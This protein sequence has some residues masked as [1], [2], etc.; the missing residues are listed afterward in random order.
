MKPV[1]PEPL[2]LDQLEAATG[3]YSSPWYGYNRRPPRPRKPMGSR[4]K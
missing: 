2:S 3:G 1:Q 4:P